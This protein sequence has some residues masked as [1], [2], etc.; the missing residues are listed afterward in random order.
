MLQTL[1]VTG[2][3]YLVIALGFLAGHFGI[4]SKPDM[5]V[6]ATVL[7]FVTISVTLWLLGPFLGW[8]P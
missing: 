1:A 3:I 5:R 2:P 7:S 8:T 6:L 4:F